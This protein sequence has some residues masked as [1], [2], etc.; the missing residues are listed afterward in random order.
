MSGLRADATQV[1]VTPAL[2]LGRFRVRGRVGLTLCVGMQIAATA[3]HTSNHNTI[4]SVR[5]PF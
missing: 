2:L 5:S 3:F 1:F 4:L